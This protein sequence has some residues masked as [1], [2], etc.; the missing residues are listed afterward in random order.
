MPGVP[1]ITLVMTVIRH[2]GRIVS[3]A[4][5]KKDNPLLI[6]LANNCK[7]FNRYVM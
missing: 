1:I 2:A 6:T 5:R 7:C 4:W 3:G